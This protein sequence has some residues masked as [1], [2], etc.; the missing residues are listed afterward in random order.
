MRSGRPPPAT[1]GAAR[2]SL[3]MSPGPSD[4]R[5]GHSRRM[6]R[7]APAAIAALL[8]LP[9]AASAYTPREHALYQDGPSGRYLL[10]QGWSTSPGQSGRFR[11]VAIPNAFNARDYTSRGNRSRV[12]WYRE[13]FTLP[14]TSGAE[15]WRLRFESVNVRADVWMNGVK[16]GSHVGGYLPFELP[17]S[18]I[19]PGSNELLVRVDGCKS[20]DDIPPAGRGQGWWNYGG[21]LREVYLRKV[22]AL[23]L[24]D[25]Q[26]KATPG[27]R[28]QF[29]AQIRNA[30]SGEQRAQ[31]Q[32]EVTGPGGPVGSSPLA[33]A[34]RPGGLNFVAAGFR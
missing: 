6:R 34:V 27:G 2:V 32:I 4:A 18:S 21:I 26:V 33:L 22:Y 9:A 3:R 20:R 24:G 19:R 30:T 11:P 25:P 28:L 8:A 10:D 13:R 16:I 15:G 17:A 7:L 12:Q 29:S 23:N 31:G 1:P 14:R 5:V